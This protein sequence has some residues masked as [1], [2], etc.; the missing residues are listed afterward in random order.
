MNIRKPEQKVV[1]AQVEINRPGG[2]SVTLNGDI[3]FADAGNHLIRAYVP[4]T[5]AR[6]T[7]TIGFRGMHIPK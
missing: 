5:G 1:S 2:L 7:R 3:V 4:S 6:R